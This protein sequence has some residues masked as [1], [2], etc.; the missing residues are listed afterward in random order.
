VS[1]TDETA[2]FAYLSKIAFRMIDA[3]ASQIEFLAIQE[4][5]PELSDADARIVDRL[6]GGAVIT[7]SIPPTLDAAAAERN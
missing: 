1:I 2:R 4:A 3:G 5:N 7:I 6:I